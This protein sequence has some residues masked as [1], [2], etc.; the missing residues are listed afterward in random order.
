MTVI[1]DADPKLPLAKADYTMVE[2][3]VTNLLENAVRH[4]PAGGQIT[5]G[6]RPAG[7]V[8]EVSVTDQGPGVRSADVER[9]FRPFERGPESRSSGL[10][11][12]ICRAFVEAHGGHI[13]V[14]TANGVQRPGSRFTFTLP[15]QRD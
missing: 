13:N 15:R 5:V 6:A 9:L 2:Q 1:V 4:S 11:L 8:I 14:E 12:A 7:D 10:G 3:I